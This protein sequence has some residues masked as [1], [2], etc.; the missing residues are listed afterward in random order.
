MI[1]KL[2]KDQ[3]DGKGV[4]SQPDLLDGS[5]DENKRVFDELPRLINGKLD[6]VIDETNRLTDEDGIAVKNP[7]KSVPYLRLNSDKVI[8]TS[9]D[10]EHWEASG[11]SGHI[12]VDADGK[13]LPQRSRMQFAEGTVEDVNGVTVVHGVRGPQGVKGDKGDKGETGAQGLRGER[14][15]VGERGPRGEQGLPGEQGPRG[16]QGAQGPQGNTG[17]QGPQ[18]I[19]GPTGATG[20]AGP[21][22]AQGAQGPQGETGAAGKDGKSLYIEDVYTTL[23]ALRK[24]IPNG[25]DNMYQ[26]QEDREC[27]IWS[28]LA[29]DWV[30][31]GKVEGPIGPQGIPGIQGP[32]GPQGET[33]ATGP[34]GPEGPQGVQGPQG[35]IGPEGPQGKQGLQGVPGNDGKSAYD[36]ALDGGYQGTE[37]Q[38]NAAL[39]NADFAG[40]KEKETPVD[41]DGVMLS[42]SA[43][44]GKAKRL[45]WSGIKTLLGKIFVSQT[46]KINGKDLSADRV[47][48]GSDIAVSTDDSSTLEK[49]VK[50][51]TNPNLL[52]N[53]F[54]G[55]PVNQR[56]QSEYTF[57]PTP[58][59]TIDRFR[60]DGNGKVTVKD[61][62]IEISND[63]SWVSV[64]Q[65][66][67]N[68]ERFAGKTL[69]ASVLRKDKSVSKLLLYVNGNTFG[70]IYK[71][72][73]FISTTVTVPDNVSSLAILFGPD[74]NQTSQY[75]AAKLEL[76]D[77]QTLAHKENG[78]WVL[79]EVPDYGEQLARCHSYFRRIAP[80]EYAGFARGCA[81]NANSVRVM[82]P[83]ETMRTSPSLNL[84]NA[85]GIFASNS[86]IADVFSLSFAK[87]WTTPESVTF[88]VS[89]TGAFV[90]G[91]E[92]ILRGGSG[93]YI[94]I[95]A[96]L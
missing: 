67:E 37:A 87:A 55:R 10:G 49:A 23:A 89:K 36:A 68:P 38:F 56:G 63:N 19:A 50:Y 5:A 72:E 27:Y 25:N 3:L 94:D 6:E 24:A 35:E 17:T 4:I 30:S 73:E 31:V 57:T 83:F 95:S 46:R 79:N 59:Y 41:T 75:I 13:E 12:V 16:V 64:L 33:G 2:T 76:G 90:D 20:P 69:T 70:G 52:D 78:V 28:E 71:S 53:W 43:D 86:G 48:T 74:T 47:F 51:R 11:S 61:D 88:D 32:E 21:R 93:G 22:G 66:L 8:E 82:I 65:Y 92:Y 84:D 80:A 9:T 91:K 29:L 34:Q 39:I 54:F 42:D 45:L 96:D 58:I 62:C 44:S 85:A 77:Q 7:D 15:P 14:G 40:A 1:E 81:Y 18:G 60:A 26:V